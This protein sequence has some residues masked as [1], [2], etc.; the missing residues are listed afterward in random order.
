[1]VD[2]ELR[3]R[4]EAVVQGLVQAVNRGDVGAVTAA[5]DHPR[6]ELIGLDRVYEGREAVERYLRDRSAAFPDQTYEIIALH[7][8][9][10]AVIAELWLRGT[11]LGEVEG[12][13]PTGRRF[14]VRIAAFFVFEDDRLVCQR[15]Y[16]NAGTIA[17][18][19]A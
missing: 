3:G 4:R 10:E 12:L 1:M 16:F 11:H 2:P 8:A 19:L 14:R 15:L 9:D 7:H 6:F 17:R 13:P 18:Q 5:M